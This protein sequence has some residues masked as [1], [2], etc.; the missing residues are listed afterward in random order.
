MHQEHHIGGEGGEGK[1]WRSDGVTTGQ[2]NGFKGHKPHPI[3]KRGEACRYLP[4]G[5]GW[6][7]KKDVFL[8]I[9]ATVVFKKK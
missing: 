9:A 4:W 1:L 7:N 6:G 8:V 3:H 2:C 5:G